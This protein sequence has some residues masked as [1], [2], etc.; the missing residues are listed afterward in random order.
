MADKPPG[1]KN[2]VVRVMEIVREM[3]T[4][5]L[6]SNPVLA[7][8]AFGFIAFILLLIFLFR[9]LPYVGQETSTGGYDAIEHTHHSE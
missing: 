3:L 7:I 9:A 4:G 5:L 8:V 1:S 2:A 6:G